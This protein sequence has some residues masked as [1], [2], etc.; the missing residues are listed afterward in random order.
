[1]SLFNMK[2][3]G[4]ELCLMVTAEPLWLGCSIRGIAGKTRR[5]YW[6][7]GSAGHLERQLVLD[8]DSCA[9][10]LGR[11]EISGFHQQV[12]DDVSLLGTLALH[13]SAVGLCKELTGGWGFSRMASMERPGVC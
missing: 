8:S 10:F 9:A 4:S 2:Q 13:R 11:F 5:W 6:P 12:Q 7:E 3:A 1:M